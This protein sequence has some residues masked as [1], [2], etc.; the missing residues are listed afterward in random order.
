MT[1]QTKDVKLE[2]KR[3]FGAIDRMDATALASF[4]TEDSVFR[5]GNAEPV[6]GNNNVREYVAGFFS[7]IMA[8]KH[9]V[10]GIWE[11][12]DVV[13]VQGEV[14]Y[15]RKDGRLVTVPFVD[16]FKMNGVLIHEFLIYID[17]SPLFS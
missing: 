14:T 12:D 3:L 2:W 5:F 7:S 11:K 15:T 1:V 6:R 16:L 13:T 8:L 17:A 4:L 10:H 9:D